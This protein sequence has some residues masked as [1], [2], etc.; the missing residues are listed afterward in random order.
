MDLENFAEEQLAETDTIIQRLEG[1]Q[2]LITQKQEAIEQTREQLHAAESALQTATDHS[3]GLEQQ[4]QELETAHNEIVDEAEERLQRLDQEN[5]TFSS[6]R[7]ELDAE[8]ARLSDF[9][10]QYE[11]KLAELESAKTELEA[12]HAELESAK[13]TITRQQAQLAK[14]E[15][16]T[17]DT[18]EHASELEQEVADLRR[19]LEDSRNRTS[20]YK[21]QLAEERAEWQTELKLLQKA[22]ESNG[23]DEGTN[24][25]AKNVQHAKSQKTPRSADRVVDRLA[26][27][28]KQLNK[29]DG[30]T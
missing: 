24:S 8:L 26:K 27:Q 28:F 21:D 13:Q 7:I 9:A 18:N 10:K 5:Q 6:E 4:L 29:P 16:G 20:R 22:I 19:E 17:R 2:A 12:S 25:V 23:S 3:A 30:Q 14:A 15:Y 1:H 11:T